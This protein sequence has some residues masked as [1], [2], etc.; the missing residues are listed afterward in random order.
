MKEW[1]KSFAKYSKKYLDIEK[2][3][4]YSLSDAQKA[5]ENTPNQLEVLAKAGV[6]DSGAKGFVDFIEGIYEFIKSGDIKT[7]S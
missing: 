5:L 3:I 4:K 6:V 1:T 7:I 2:I